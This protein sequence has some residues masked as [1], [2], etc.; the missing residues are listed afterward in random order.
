MLLFWPSLIAQAEHLAE[1][2]FRDL[3][4]LLDLFERESS[5]VSSLE[6]DLDTIAAAAG[7]S[8]QLVATVS[9]EPGESRMIY[10]RRRA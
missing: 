8:K 9:R 10:S 2:T 4:P 5:F 1:T 7:F 6:L 3:D